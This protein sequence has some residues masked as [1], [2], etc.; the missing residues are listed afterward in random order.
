MRIAEKYD[1][2]ITG[3]VSG[4]LLPVLV[5]VSIYIFTAHGVGLANYLERVLQPYFVIHAITLCVFPNVLIFLVYNQF[6]MLRAAR[7]VL[8][9]T[10]GYALIAFVLK[11]L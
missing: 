2:L 5:G 4:A 8:S 7:G 10:I 3:I 11:L 9:V 1:T 6:D